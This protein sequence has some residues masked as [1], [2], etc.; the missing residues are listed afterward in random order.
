MILSPQDISHAKVYSRIVSLVPSQTELLYDLGL[1]EEV[2]GI[3]KFCV[4]PSAWYQ[5]RTRVGGTKDVNIRTVSQ[6]K[7]GLIIANKEENFKEQVESL[8][9]QFDVFVTD[10]SNLSDA[11]QMIRQVGKLVGRSLEAAELADKIDSG[12]QQLNASVETKRK[13]KAAYIIWQNPYM[14]V[15]GDTFINDMMNRSGLENI[16]DNQTRYPEIFLE[17]ILNRQ[18]EMMLLSTEPYPFT[19]T[20]VTAMQ[21]KLGIPVIL[22][23]GE[24][25]SWYGSRLIKAISYLENFHQKIEMIRMKNF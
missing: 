2:V 20:H 24:M 19:K 9:K 10:V 12:F 1:N 6:L 16:F 13:L 7:P 17:E 4:H 15:G 8:S 14:T 25:F 3:T 18:S 23:N 5:T 11:L 21:S 22:V